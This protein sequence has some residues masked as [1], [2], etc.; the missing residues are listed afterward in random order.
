MNNINGP[1]RQAAS[2][3]RR[4]RRRPLD[5][6]AE[7]LR[8]AL[9][10]FTRKGFHA[11]S[12]EEIGQEAGVSKATAHLYFG[13]KERLFTEAVRSAIDAVQAEGAR[14]VGE[15]EGSVRSQ[16]RSW[17]F[18]WRAIASNHRVG[19]LLKLAMA[20]SQAFP[21]LAHQA[22]ALAG[23]AHREVA[24]LLERGI[25]SGEIRS[26]DT[27]VTAQLLLA[28]FEF[29][30]IRRTCGGAFGEAAAPDDAYFSTYLDLVLNGLEVVRGGDD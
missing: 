15:R 23:H 10:V 3:G 16:L 13:S 12:M 27:A 26:C 25:R 5:R 29:H 18:A 14:H 28:P 24:N 7:L 4:R 30:E 8:A 9:A 1:A 19:E 20:E 11:G 6:K 17:L 21:V 2:S 22:Q